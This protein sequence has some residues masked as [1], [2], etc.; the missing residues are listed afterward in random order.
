MIAKI[1]LLI[2]LVFVSLINISAQNSDYLKNLKSN[3]AKGE[4]KEKKLFTYPFH[5][6][7]CLLLFEEWKNK[8]EKVQY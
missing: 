1:R 8:E 7:E 4:N 5:R 3:F 6:E 2:I